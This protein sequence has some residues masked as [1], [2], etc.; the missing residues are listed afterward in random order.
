MPIK[1]INEKKEYYMK[2]TG[3]QLIFLVDI[4][5]D[6]LEVQMGYDWVFKSSRDQR[7]L[8]HDN[9]LKCLLSQQKVEVKGLNK[10]KLL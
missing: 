3:E 8:F 6:S 9:L 7:K 5:K 4:L 1:I 10:S 2:I